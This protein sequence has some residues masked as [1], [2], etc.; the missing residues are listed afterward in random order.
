MEKSKPALY[1]SGSIEKSEDPDTWR[2]KMFRELHS[3][4]KVIIPNK[5]D[6]PF[7][8]DDPEYKTWMKNKFIMP[9]MISVSTSKYFF[10]KIDHQVFQ[11]AGTISEVTT[12]CWLGKDII[13]FLDGITEKEIP[14]WTLGCLDGVIFVSSINEAIEIYKRKH[15]ELERKEKLLYRRRKRK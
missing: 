2:K 11:G 9:D 12:A 8:K 1:L 4:Y 3:Y 6:L 15:K 10:V 14:S 13:V 7:E 5:A